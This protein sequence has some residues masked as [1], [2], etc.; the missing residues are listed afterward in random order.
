MCVTG[1]Q[2]V[3]TVTLTPPAYIS[4]LMVGHVWKKVVSL[5]RAGHACNWNEFSL[6]LAL[7]QLAEAKLA[8]SLQKFFSCALAIEISFTSTRPGVNFAEITI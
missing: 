1:L 3:V 7:H 6:H 2:A 5:H 8:Q 4:R